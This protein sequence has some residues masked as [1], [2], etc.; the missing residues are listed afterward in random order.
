MLEGFKL[1]GFN[2]DW[3]SVGLLSG[4]QGFMKVDKRDVSIHN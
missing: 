3:E 4:V 2:T 1:M